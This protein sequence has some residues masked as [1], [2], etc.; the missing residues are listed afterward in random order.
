VRRAAPAKC[1]AEC[2]SRHSRK[3]ACRRQTTH[4]TTPEAPCPT[5]HHPARAFLPLTSRL[6]T[7]RPTCYISHP[8][9]GHWWG[10]GSSK[11][12]RASLRQQ[13]TRRLRRFGPLP[14]STRTTSFCRDST[15][16]PPRL[17][18]QQRTPPRPFG[19]HCGFSA[20]AHLSLGT[21]SPSE[22]LAAEPGK[23]TAPSELVTPTARFTGWPSHT[24]HCSTTCCTDPQYNL[25][26]YHRYDRSVT[27]CA[28]L[29]LHTHFNPRPPPIRYR[30]TYW[31]T[32]SRPN[33]TLTR[34]A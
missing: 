27:S 2:T 33:D 1:A 22:R 9:G 20:D 8:T 30:N 5:I 29:V 26:G 31:N 16:P 10:S 15:R 4:S 28:E 14:S 23:H 34:A 11:S 32:D 13:S 24:T 19:T 17:Y 3:P 21:S 6:R 25:R 18:T 7:S 12:P